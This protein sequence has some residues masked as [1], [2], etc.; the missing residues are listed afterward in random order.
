MDETKRLRIDR[1]G[2]HAIGLG[3]GLLLAS[4][5]LGCMIAYAAHGSSEGFRAAGHSVSEIG[6]IAGIVLSVVGLAIIVYG[7]VQLGRSREHVSHRTG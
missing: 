1:R 5:T 6:G 3:A 4:V 7:L 2:R